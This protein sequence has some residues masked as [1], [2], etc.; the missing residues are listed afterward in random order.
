MGKQ[1]EPGKVRIYISQK[2]LMCHRF[3]DYDKDGSELADMQFTNLKVNGAL[4][5]ALFKYTP[6]EG[7]L[8]M[9]MTKGMPDFRGMM[10]DLPNPPS[11]EGGE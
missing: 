1:P 3:R 7:A 5:P 6:P 10:K 2:D 8:V 4:D 9:D 11:E